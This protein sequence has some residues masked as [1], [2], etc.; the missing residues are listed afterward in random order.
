MHLLFP[1][2]PWIEEGRDH[3]GRWTVGT[4]PYNTFTSR[5]GPVFL[6]VLYVVRLHIHCSS[7]IIDR[8][9]VDT[10][11]DPQEIIMQ[12][13]LTNGQQVP[14]ESV[15]VLVGWLT[16]FR[17]ENFTAEEAQDLSDKFESMLE[18]E[19]QNGSF[20]PFPEM[21]DCLLAKKYPS[22]PRAGS[23]VDQTAVSCYALISDLRRCYEWK[24]KGRTLASDANATSPSRSFLR[25]ICSYL[26]F[27]LRSFV[28]GSERSNQAAYVP[29]NHSHHGEALG[30]GPFPRGVNLRINP[31]QAHIHLP[32]HHQHE[33]YG[34]S[35]ERPMYPQ[36]PFRNH[37]QSRSQCLYRPGEG[38]S[39]PDFNTMPPAPVQQ[40]WQGHQRPSETVG[41]S[42]M[43]SLPHDVAR[44]DTAVQYNPF[45]PSVHPAAYGSPRTSHHRSGQYANWP[46]NGA[47]PSRSGGGGM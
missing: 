26:I 14:V 38:Q 45:N 42:S 18:G 37:P 4:V 43:G 39:M 35:Q 10:A 23:V 34:F 5:P 41:P 17:G 16:R 40:V 1:I 24:K 30:V 46:Q 19:G 25:T 36:Q 31:S 28:D 15:S 12:S 22:H 44:G 32:V 47:G 13:F 2:I 7:P 9:S 6:I 33:G 21:V 3:L 11:R 8:M 27:A 20:T 29:P